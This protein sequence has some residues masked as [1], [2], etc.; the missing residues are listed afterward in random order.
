MCLFSQDFNYQKQEIQCFICGTAVIAPPLLVFSTGRESL[1]PTDTVS[2]G[3]L[4]G[5]QSV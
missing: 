4:V 5:A 1:M 3:N 2:T